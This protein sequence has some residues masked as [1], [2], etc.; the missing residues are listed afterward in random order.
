MTYC[1][2]IDLGTTYTSAAIVRDGRAETVPLGNRAP[3]IPSVVFLG[4]DEQVLTGEAASRRGVTE[5]GRVA[6]EFKRRLG[7]PT[8][9][10][11][12]GSPYSADGLMAKLLRWVVDLVTE[13]QGGAPDA[14]VVSH[15][16]NWGPYKTDLL[17]QAITRAGLEGVFTITEPEAA[18]FHYASQERVDQGAII[19]VFDLGGGTFDAAVLRKNDDAFEVLGD[20]QGI[21]RLGGVDFDE[22]VFQFVLAALGDAIGELD[23]DDTST[24]AAVARLR[25]EC[26]DAK[27]AL[28]SDTEVSIP[29]LLPNLQTEVRLTRAEFEGLV[30]PTLGD[31]ITALERA[32]RSAGVDA[33][34]VTT[35]LLVGG[36]SRIPLVAQ[37]VSSAIGRPVS[38]DAHPKHGV[39]LGAALHASRRVAET[40]NAVSAPDRGPEQIPPVIPAAAPTLTTPAVQAVAAEPRGSSTAT[41]LPRKPLFIGLGVAAL[42]I[43]VVGGALLLDGENDDPSEAGTDVAAATTLPADD[44]SEPSADVAAVTTSVTADVSTT[45]PAALAATTTNPVATTAESNTTS[46]IP[47]GPFVRLTD[48]SLV[49]GT[50]V[51]AYEVTGYVPQIDGG[52]DSLHI[53]LYLNDID[54]EN[55]GTTGPLPG[56]WDITDAPTSF[57]TSVSPV[58]AATRGATQLCALVATVTH[59]VFDPN[60]GTCLDLPT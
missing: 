38:V 55:A 50:Y 56:T 32:L 49:D 53:H 57:R 3:V 37:M 5:P 12:G 60:S 34:E 43:A 33:G 13:Q 29:V 9:I 2:G 31:A 25:Q 58:D 39:A 24:L 41:R 4:D 14:I 44:A 45:S 21:E 18:A 20:P 52:P 30:R 28:S 8:P 46:S 6:R 54:P 59:G 11:V 22:A 17:D 15:P 48:V 42:V 10:I 27:E 16:A 36:S 47:A 19:A 35:V 23:P 7:D 1:L 26:V 40:S 51:A